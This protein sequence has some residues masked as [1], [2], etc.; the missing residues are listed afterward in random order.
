MRTSLFIT[1]MTNVRCHRVPLFPAGPDVPP[2]KA[3][4]DYIVHAPI[5]STDS[6]MSK[7]PVR[8][9]PRRLRS[10]LT[11]TYSSSSWLSVAKSFYFSFDVD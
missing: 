4:A 2:V 8:P 3:H 6:N 1:A 10:S 11:S 9:S 5:N 7:S